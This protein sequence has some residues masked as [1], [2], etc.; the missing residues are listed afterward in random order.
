MV[1]VVVVDIVIIFIIIYTL[2]PDFYTKL[3]NILTILSQ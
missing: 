3:M 1:I 2:F